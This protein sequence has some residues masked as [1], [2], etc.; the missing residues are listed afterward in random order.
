MP[1]PEITSQVAKNSSKVRKRIVANISNTPLIKSKVNPLLFFKSENF[2]LT[3]SFKVRGALSKLSE[4]PADKEII[5]ASS[6]NHGIA[7]SFAAKT[8][9]HKLTVVLPENVAPAKLEKIKSYGTRTLLNPGD[10]GLAERKARELAFSG[11]YTYV[12][13][14]NDDLVI[15]G[16]GTIGFEILEQ[17]PKVKNIFI[18]MGGGGLI[19]GI[20]SV[21]KSL[22]PKVKIIGVS[23][24]NSAALA[25]SIN[26]GKVVET[27]HLE[28]LADGCA[29]GV[30][31]DSITLPI[32]S[33]VIDRIIHCNEEDI[34]AALKILA[35]DEKVLVEGAA[36]LALAG[37]LK[38]ESS[39]KMETSV[40]LLCG[41]NF[42]K[43]SILKVIA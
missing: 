24:I 39:F 4:L 38:H 34:I 32:A 30:D 11:K 9:G 2:Q 15:A 12:S 19:S 17:L 31:D 23:A 29:G 13:P 42:D 20:G 28:T 6:G 35:W 40:I 25:A 10:S 37:F 5:T 16:Q 41:A 8:T 27:E 26:Q 22:S 14:Y 3:G 21:I 18:S 33:K 36:A 7:C 43:A 1:S